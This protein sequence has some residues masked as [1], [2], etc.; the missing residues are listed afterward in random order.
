MVRYCCAVSPDQEFAK[1]MPGRYL[2]YN[3]IVLHAMIC[4]RGIGT[5]GMTW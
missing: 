2:V 3:M 5:T 4:T 1:I